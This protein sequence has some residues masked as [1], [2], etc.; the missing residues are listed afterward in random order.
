MK[1]LNQLKL[2]SKAHITSIS[3]SCE[4]FACRLNAM[5]ICTGQEIEVLRIAWFGPIHVR[6]GMT[7]L[8]IRKKDAKCIQ[9]DD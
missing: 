3:C 8:F 1:T 5:G 6:I 4:G 7:E 2:N 9:V